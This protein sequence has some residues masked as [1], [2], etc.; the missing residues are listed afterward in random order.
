MTCQWEL[1]REASMAKVVIYSTDYCPYCS[2]AK[3]LFQ[4]KNVSFDEIN[5]EGDQEKRDWLVQQTGQTTV[6]QIF[7]DDKS[8]GGFQDVL[9]LEQSGELDK[10]LG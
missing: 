5:V 1:G 9:A 10:L 2:A 3:N 4:S 6:P 7:I 8:Y